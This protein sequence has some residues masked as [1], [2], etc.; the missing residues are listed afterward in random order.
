MNN[1]DNNL[2]VR[3]SKR[4]AKKVCGSDPAVIAAKIEEEEGSTSQRQIDANSNI[5]FGDSDSSNIVFG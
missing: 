1:E 5:V 4:I 2:P 3:V